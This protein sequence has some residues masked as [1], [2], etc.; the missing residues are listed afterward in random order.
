MIRRCW[1]PVLLAV[2]VVG[3]VACSNPDAPI[4]EDSPGPTVT[5]PSPGAAG[6]PTV[7]GSLTVYAPPEL[8]AVGTRLVRGFMKQNPQADVNLVNEAPR[9]SMFRILGG[10][11]GGV[12]ISDAQS[13]S[14]FGAYDHNLPS[15]T[16]LAREAL[17]LAVPKGNPGG[18]KTVDDLGKPP[19]PDMICTPPY[20]LAA[21]QSSPTDLTVPINEKAAADCGNTLVDEVAAKK[22]AGALVPGSFAGYLRG[23]RIDR[24]RVPLTGNLVVTYSAIPI[25]GSEVATGFINFARSDAGKKMFEDSGYE[26]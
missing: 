26:A 3:V 15:S 22:L 10:A 11:P 12:F 1:G 13:I 8:T 21:S 20:M 16:R 7:S 25:E 24:I 23:N 5:L 17:V 4:N 6:G 14:D 2:L 9:L 18:V 19:G